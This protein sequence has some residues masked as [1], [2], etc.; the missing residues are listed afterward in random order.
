MVE[1]VAPLNSK[2]HRLVPLIRRR[3]ARSSARRCGPSSGNGGGR[4]SRRRRE[5]TSAAEPRFEPCDQFAL[6]LHLCAQ[7]ENVRRRHPSPISRQLIEAAASAIGA[8]ATLALGKEARVVTAI[9]LVH[10]VLRTRVV[11]WL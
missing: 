5:S 10:G 9:Q 2:K 4:S 6:A 3:C 11:D 7:R 1:F 8:H